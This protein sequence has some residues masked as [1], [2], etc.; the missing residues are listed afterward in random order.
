M[1]LL[2]EAKRSTS[3]EIKY[4]WLPDDIII[5]LTIFEDLIFGL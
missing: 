3:T 4:L 2:E 1:M 5:L